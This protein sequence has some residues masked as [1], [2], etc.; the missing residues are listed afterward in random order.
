[1]AVQGDEVCLSR[2]ETPAVAKQSA[3]VKMKTFRDGMFAAPL[4]QPEKVDCPFPLTLECVQMS[5]KLI[6]GSGNIGKL[7]LLFSFYNGLKVNVYHFSS[8]ASL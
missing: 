5:A 6:Y 2:I 7:Y 3:A 1:M 4:T 8:L